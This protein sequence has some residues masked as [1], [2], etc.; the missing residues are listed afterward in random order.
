LTLIIS[1][2]PKNRLLGKAAKNR[3]LPLLDTFRTLDW[4]EIRERLTGLEYILAGI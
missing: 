4:R 1:I 3:G 2:L